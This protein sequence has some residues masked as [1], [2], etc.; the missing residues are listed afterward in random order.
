MFNMNILSQVRFLTI[1]RQLLNQDHVCLTTNIIIFHKSTQYQ[2][3][4]LEGDL[5]YT[6]VLKRL[7]TISNTSDK[8]SKARLE[9]VGDLVAMA[10]QAIIFIGDQ[11]TK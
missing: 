7:N 11:T 5:L 8:L 10:L 2:H 1:L 4:L 9:V 6:K 3:Q